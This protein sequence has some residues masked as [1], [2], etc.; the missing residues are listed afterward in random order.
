MIRQLVSKIS[1]FLLIFCTSA[2]VTEAPTSHYGQIASENPDHVYEAKGNN[3][4]VAAAHP[5]ASKAGLKMLKAGGNAVDAFVATSFMISVVRPQSTG[6]GGGGFAL[7]HNT[8]NIKGKKGTQVYD[9]RERAPLAATKDMYLDKKG[10]PK[11]FIYKGNVVKNASVNGHLAAGTPGIVAGLVEMH[12]N[13]GSLPLK[14]VMQPAID[15]AERGFPVYKGLSTRIGWR[16]EIMDNFEGT[17]KLFMPGG[18]A[19]EV[20]D[21]LVNKDLA[22]TLKLIAKKGRDGFYK[23]EVAALII[24]EMKRGKGLI[25]QKD[26]DSYTVKK[27]KPIIGDYRGFKIVSMPPPSSGGIHIVQMLNILSGYDYGSYGHNTTKSLHLL[28]ESMRRAFADR[29]EYLGDPEFVKV[30]IKGLTTKK[31]ADALRKT[32]DLNKASDSKTIGPGK[33]F[34]YES[35][36]TTHL[37]VVDKWG[38]AVTSTQTVNYTYGSCVIVEGAGF[39]LNDEMDDFS[40]K[41]GVPNAFGLLGSEANAIAAKKTMLSSMSPTLVFN[42]EGGVEMILGSPGGPRIISATLQTILNVIDHKQ[43]YLAAVHSTRIHHQWLPDQIRVEGDELPKEVLEGLSALGHKLDKNKSAIGDVQ[44]I[45]RDK[46]GGWIG[47]SDRRSD[48]SPM[49]Y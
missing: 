8:G 21:T 32:I 12:K 28:A 5:M 35:S 46:K 22:K 6:I 14:T 37:S 40:K 27:S 44:A 34:D 26:L 20:G 36:S 38:N 24:K 45:F 39:F 4:M 31:Y 29:A 42:K 3:G 47:V 43:P 15:A 11:N 30:P 2:C 19:L 49:G 18:K 33:P 13:H 9:F 25:T 7:L 1:I 41:P 23:G 10:N 48:G 16:R 17:R